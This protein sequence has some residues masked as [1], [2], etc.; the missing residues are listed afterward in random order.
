MPKI[1]VNRAKRK[2]QMGKVV[3][4][5]ALGTNF[6]PDNDTLDQLGALGL[7]D[8]AWIDMEAGPVTWA[9]LSDFSRACDLWGITSLACVTTGESWMIGRAL[10]RG[11]Q[12]VVVPH[13]NTKEAAQ[14]VVRA[15]KF[16]PIGMRGVGFSRQGYGVI[17]Y[18]RK[19]NDEIMIVVQIEGVEGIKN[20][21][22]I[23]TVDNIDVFH[24]PPGDLAQ[25]M[26]PQYLG[27]SN[28]PDVQAVIKKAIK[29]VVT[30]GRIAG[31][32]VDDD[33]VEHYLDLG[34][35]FLRYS[36]SSY[37]ISGLEQFRKKVETRMRAKGP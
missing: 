7:L 27:R 6:I 33:N 37:L 25:S 11:V 36:G 28:H 1:R 10:D 14:R 35:R 16:A 21:A 24:F 23:L 31:T 9:D 13:V 32:R 22:E 30:S 8:A 4:A 12:G 3:L 34:A 20:L 15:A 17:D 19:A 5:P 18:R 2:L 29:Q 26:G